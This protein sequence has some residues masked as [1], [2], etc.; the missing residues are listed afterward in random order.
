MGLLAFEEVSCET[1]MAGMINRGMVRAPVGPM[2]VAVTICGAIR[3]ENRTRSSAQDPLLTGEEIEEWL[4]GQD[5]LADRQNGRPGSREEMQSLAEAA[6]VPA[7]ASNVDWSSTRVF[8]MQDSRKIDRAVFIN[9]KEREREG[10][11]E[12]KTY[13]P[14]R[15]QLIDSLRGLT[16]ESGKPLF[17]AVLEGSAGEE[18]VE[19]ATADVPDLLFRVNRPA[20]LDRLIFRRKDDPDPI[21]MVQVRWIYS[22]GTG[23]HTPDGIVVFAGEG[24]TPPVEL[25]PVSLYDI[26]PTVLWH[27]GLPR[28]ERQLGRVL[29]SAF[30]RPL[31]NRDL[32]TISSWVD[33]IEDKR[34]IAIPKVGQEEIEQLRALGYVQ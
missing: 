8:G 22:Q 34:T 14:F 24:T 16:T 2:E 33:A 18:P 29:R 23:D 28:D 27:M 21:P 31:A 5:V 25:E 1:L 26:A 10:V 13:E 19:E 20:L 32:F 9:V 4:A 17:L 30:A 3:A 11:I 6:S 7:G 12:R 15:R